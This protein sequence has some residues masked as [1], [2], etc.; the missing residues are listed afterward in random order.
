MKD[1]EREREEWIW[2]GGGDGKEERWEETGDD[3]EVNEPRNQQAETKTRASERDCERGACG[4]GRKAATLPGDAL[5][6]FG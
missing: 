1:V 2:V 4:G 6:A 3:E 5:D